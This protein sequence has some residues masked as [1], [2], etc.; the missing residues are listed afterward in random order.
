MQSARIRL[1]ITDLVSD[2]R[3]LGRL[4]GRAVFV[5]QA[6]PG[7]LVEA[8]LCRTRP[9]MFEARHLATLRPSPD[10]RPAPCPHAA[11]CGGCPWQSLVGEAQLRWKTRIVRDALERLGG[12][13]DPPLL[14]TLPS[15]QEW[16]Y[17]N[18]MEFAFAREGATLRLGLRERAS[19]RIVEV[20]DCR[21]QSAASMRVVEAAR[22]WLR[23]P[24]GSPAANL[25]WKYLVVRQ[26]SGGGLLAEGILGPHREARRHGEALGRAL[27]RT[28][29]ELT[30]FVLS[31]RQSRLDVAYGERI[32]VRLGEVTLTER[33]Y[34]PDS[35]PPQDTG[36][37]TAAAPLTLRLSPAAFFQVNTAG[38]NL[39][40]AEAARLLRP[41]PHERLWDVYC[42]VGSIGLFLAP[43]AGEVL[44]VELTRPAVELARSNARDAG[45]LHCRFEAG[46]ARTLLPRF[47]AA[48][49]AVLDPPRSGLHPDIVKLLLERSPERLL[50]I[51]CNPATLARDAA[52]LQPGF[53]LSAVRPV[54][55]FPQTP[56]VEC[57]A[58]FLA[59]HPAKV[60]VPELGSGLRGNQ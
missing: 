59:R 40:Y 19:R 15:P 24:E 26:P 51:S 34:R 10:E 31:Q 21:L 23:T 33:L 44:G 28:V 39:L 60:P 25:P 20:T 38:A 16:G 17:R 46:E 2:G 47:P 48:H 58:L 5:D 42:G 52:L 53:Q 43:W 50:Y 54:D 27:L 11:A 8:E 29:P 30:G 3:G 6:L 1:E 45:F 14:P 9:N 13:A 35:L 4:D 36:P 22:A 56:H 12:L 32:L 55:L 57:A 7:Q 41:Q 18:K 49:A 37:V